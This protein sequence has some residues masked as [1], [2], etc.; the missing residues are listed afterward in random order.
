MI[1][2]DLAPEDITAEVLEESGSLEGLQ[3]LAE[4]A[5]AQL[6]FEV[7]GVKDRSW[8]WRE[9]KD[10]PPYAK[11]TV[12]FDFSKTYA[13]SRIVLADGAQTPPPFLPQMSPATPVKNGETP[14]CA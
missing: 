10:K 6:V 9:E 2:R 8:F 4:D 3:F 5:E 12:T 14:P 11:V 7:T 13:D 1:F